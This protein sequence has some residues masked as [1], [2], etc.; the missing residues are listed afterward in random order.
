MADGE[1]SGA[2]EKK[3]DASAQLDLFAE[4]TDKVASKLD[5]VTQQISAL[6]EHVAQAPVQV[7]APQPQ[8]KLPRMSEEQVFALEEKGE[9]TRAQAMAFLTRQ[10]REDAKE[11]TRKEVA[12]AIDVARNQSATANIAAK[13]SEYQKAIPGLQNK[14]TEEWNRVAAVFRELVNEGHPHN[15]LLT[16]LTA[17]R[18]V[19]GVDPSQHAEVRDRT[20]ERNSRE[21][22]S[23]S[24][25]AARTTRTTRA[26]SNEPDPDL[27]DQV[28]LYVGRMINIGQ[29]KGW[30]DPKAVAYAKRWKDGPTRR[31]S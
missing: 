16:E 10:A 7:V 30:D 2:D 22:A 23:P 9:I 11:E 20:K 19:Y 4:R 25:S 17:I 12:A 26:R 29:Y 5:A 8:Q 15:S 31:A 21:P 3:P 24:S 6:A 27:P 28:R 13:I 18:Q 1:E 14:G